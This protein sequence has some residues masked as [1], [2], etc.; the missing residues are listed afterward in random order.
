MTTNSI[1]TLHF[2]KSFHERSVDNGSVLL[3][4]SIGYKHNK[5]GAKFK[6]LVMASNSSLCRT[7]ISRKR[8]G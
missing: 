7:L 8:N 1:T 5:D 4:S 2:D 3:W 6:C